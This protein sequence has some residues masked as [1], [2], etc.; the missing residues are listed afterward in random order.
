MFKCWKPAVFQDGNTVYLDARP[1]VI[2]IL[3]IA[4]VNKKRSTSGSGPLPHFPSREITL[5]VEND[6][7]P[8]ENEMKSLLYRQILSMHVKSS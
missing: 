5:T 3:H 2:I 7:K 1:P 6:F 4:F 8:H